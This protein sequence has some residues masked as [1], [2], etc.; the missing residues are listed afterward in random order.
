VSTPKLALTDT[1]AASATADAVVIGTVQHTDGLRLAPGAERLDEAFDGGLVETLTLLGATGKADEVV[2]LPTRGVVGAPVLVAVGLGKP[3]ADGMVSPEQARRA[4][5]AAAR[6]L[7]GVGK[8]VTTLST[9]DIGAAAEGSV[10]GAYAFTRYQSENGSQPLRRVDLIVPSAKDREAAAELKQAA[11][12]AEGVAAARDLVNTPPNDLYPGSFAERAAELAREAGMDAEV[13]DEKALRRAGFGGVLAVGAGSSRPPRL[14]RL[15][16][17]P[18]D[19]RAKVAL[20]GKGVTF[21]TGGISIK[22]APDMDVM[23]SDMAGGAAVVLTAVTAARLKLPIELITTVPMVENMPSGTAYRPGDVL[24][25]Y[26]GK[27]VE[28]L[29][30]DA[31]GRLILADAIVRACEDEP[32]YLLEASTLTGGQIVALGGRIAGVMGE[33]ALRDRVTVHAQATGEGGWA[34][35]LPDELRADLDSKLADIANVTGNRWASMLVG[36]VF[37]QEFV[38]DGMPWAHIDV[39]G[40]AYNTGSPYGYTGKGGTGVPVRTL[41][42]M[43]ADIATNG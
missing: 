16:Y 2:K 15:H 24:T 36:G 4:S 29:N 17:R 8:A 25:M 35:P 27:T 21:D 38:R 40:P 30:T 19:A 41:C 34:M 20:V 1:D 5:G 42:A 28:V 43:L 37:L 23:T 6:A 14:V 33:P 12:V 32:D 13:L 10:L 31:E 11:A 9:V 18:A 26:G 22:P 7:T 39:A 3:N